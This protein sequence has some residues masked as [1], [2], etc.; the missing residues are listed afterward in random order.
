MDFGVC[1][2]KATDEQKIKKY[3]IDKNFISDLYPQIS[4]ISQII[5]VPSPAL[6]IRLSL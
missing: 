6:R 3:T 2:A 1:C 5:L 4:Q